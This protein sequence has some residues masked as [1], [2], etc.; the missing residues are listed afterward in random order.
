M[1]RR[2][3]FTLVELLVVIAIIGILV[4]LLLPA[5]QAAREA[6]RRS[7]CINQLKQLAL[8]AL[9]HELAHKHLP[10]GGWGWR[11]IGDPNQGFGKDQPGGWA[12]NLL[13]FIEEQNLRD[14]G[15]GVTNAAELETIMMSMVGTPVP[16]FYCPS[17]RSPLAYPLSQHGYLAN[18]LGSCIEGQCQVSRGDYAANSGNINAQDPGGGPGSLD[19]GN[20]DFKFDMQGA[21]QLVQNGVVFQRSEVRMSQIVDGTSKTALI[22]EKLLNPDR[23]VDGLGDNDDQSI[24]T[25]HDFDTIAYTGFDFRIHHPQQ[26][27]PGI[28]LRYYFGSAHP[29]AFQMAYCDGSV[30]TIPYHIDELVY[31]ALGSR[32]QSTEISERRG[33]DRG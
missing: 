11:W 29:S 3:A 25:G 17:R 12:Y 28:N 32:D 16:I 7:Q 9:N 18:N 19:Y 10:S 23:Y 6:A 20:Y 27:Q 22:G 5:I 33:P 30:Q 21:I 13:P 31:K 14:A 4:A 24:Y 1:R 2:S 8:G 15:S 26:D